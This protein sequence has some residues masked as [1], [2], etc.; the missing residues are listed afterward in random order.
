M[1]NYKWSLGRFAIGA[2]VLSLLL[3]GAP[4]EGQIHDPRAI[5]SDPA[6]AQEPIAPKLGGLSDYH[7]EV[8]T[9]NPESQAFFD[10]GL[11]LTYGFNHSE[12]LRAFKEAIRLDPN[13]AMAHWGWALALGPNL[14]LPMMPDVVP[15]ALDAMQRAQNLASGVSDQ[16]RDFIAALATRYTDDP[17]ADRSSFDQAY[18]SAMEKLFAKYPDSADAGT[19]YGAAIMNT[20]PW[21]Y[22]NRDGSP[23]PAAER[24]LQVF[25]QVLQL[26]PDHPGA[27]HYWIHAVEAVHPKRAVEAAD[28]LLPLMPGIGHMVHMP[29]HIY[30]RVGRYADAYDAN[31]AAVEA[32]E[33]YI[34]QCRAQGMYPLNYYPHNQH[35][36]AWAAMF[37]GRKEEAMKASRAVANGIPNASTNEGRGAVWNLYETFRSQPMYTMGRFGMWQEALREPAPEASALFMNGVW[38]YVRS[39]AHTHTGNLRKAR[40]ELKYLRQLQSQVAAHPDYTI[41]FGSAT[42]MLTIASEIAA[43]EIAAAKG[44]Y[45]E[46]LAHLETGVRL[47]DSLLYNEPPDWYFPVRHILGAV[48]LEAGRATEAEVIYWAD[49]AKNPEN[50]FALFGLERA[51]R[52]QG[53]TDLADQTAE[54]FTIAWASADGALKS[55]RY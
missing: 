24:M 11:R 17:E 6:T 52:A 20:T 19:L 33:D 32:D 12:A 10:Q 53:K 31:F 35:F 1:K 45:T 2:L 48:L 5:D 44:D 18:A 38:R 8:T 13:N 14:N 16:E 30:M 36:L 4:A 7:F 22:W 21:N 40:K 9:S 37:Q 28:R 46:A 34:T 55:S 26:N 39:L 41:G 54:R 25:E 23:K 27:L 49:L 29:S 47:E 15:Q 43:G 50:G 3:A 51:L 42:T